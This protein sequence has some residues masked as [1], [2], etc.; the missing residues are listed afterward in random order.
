MLETLETITLALIPG[1]IL[2]DLVYRARQYKAPR[3]WRLRAL[4]V[5]VAIFFLTGEIAALWG[6][7]LEGISLFHLAQYGTAVGVVVGILVYELVHYWYHRLAHSW[8]WL[9]RAGHQMHHSAESLDAFGAYYRTFEATTP[10]FTAVLR[11]AGRTLISQAFEG[12]SLQPR[13]FLPDRC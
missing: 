3:S 9:W 6:T 7:A 5:T 8:N 10:D 12:R 1:F 4:V 13:G 2:L 11:V